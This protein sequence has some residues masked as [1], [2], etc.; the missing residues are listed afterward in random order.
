MIARVTGEMESSPSSVMNLPCGERQNLS[1]PLYLYLLLRH[2]NIDLLIWLSHKWQKVTDSGKAILH[3]QGVENEPACVLEALYSSIQSTPLCLSFS[4]LCRDVIINQALR[5]TP[6][7]FL[8]TWQEDNVRQC[9]ELAP[10]GCMTTHYG[11][12]MMTT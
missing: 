5:W 12:L 9:L 8:G 3:K 4:K 1:V 11:C 6:L 10:L 7:G 2:T